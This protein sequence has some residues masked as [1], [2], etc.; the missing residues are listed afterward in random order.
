M[1]IAFISDIHSNL[2]AFKSILKKIDSLSV[3]E[4][5]CVGD[6]VGYNAYPKECLNILRNREIISVMGNHDFATVHGNTSWFNNLGIM[7]VKHSRENLE[8]D[9]IDFLKNLPYE[10]SFNIDNIN[11]YLTHGSPRDN[12]FEYVH[13]HFSFEKIKEIGKDVSSDVIVL[14][15]THIP[16]GVEVDNKLLLN[17]G[18]VGQPRDGIS[19][20]S[21]MLFDTK[22]HS[23]RWFRVSYDIESACKAIFENNLP[24]VLCKRLKIGGKM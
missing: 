20:S 21:F 3:D 12:L 7:G 22:N 17:P 13:P 10:L 14:G 16:M 8:K 18:S 15:H 9:D 6:T 19:K 23:Y 1:K 5:F 2:H 11:F 24:Q 4:I